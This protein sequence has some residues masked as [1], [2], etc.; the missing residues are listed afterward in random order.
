M[1]ATNLYNLFGQV[2]DNGSL[3]VIDTLDSLSDHPILGANMLADTGFAPP[4][5]I[6]PGLKA[7]I[8]TVSAGWLRVG[9]LTPFMELLVQRGLNGAIL[10][11]QYNPVV[12]IDAGTP[13]IG[14]HA[15]ACVDNLGYL[16]VREV[17]YMQA[18]ELAPPR[19]LANLKLRTD[20]NGY[21]LV[22]IAI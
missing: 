11:N 14:A 19:P 20:E 16:C 18:G 6:T 13:T 3:I 17:P 7:S 1:S 15:K 8:Q 9:P 10:C 12:A 5:F 2:D 22:A 21:L 4:G